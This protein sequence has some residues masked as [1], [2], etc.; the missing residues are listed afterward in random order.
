MATILNSEII[1][2]NPASLVN[3]FN[4]A[5]TIE[6]TKK[7]FRIRG[8]YLPGKGVNYSGSYYDSLKDESSE[9]CITLIVPGVIRHKITPQQTIEFTGYLTKKVQP[10]VGKIELHINLIELLSQKESEHTEEQIKVFEV[11]QKKAAEGYKDV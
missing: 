6:A 2:Y 7:A 3:I 5:L 1:T 10:N 9:A 8:I 4:N 11:L